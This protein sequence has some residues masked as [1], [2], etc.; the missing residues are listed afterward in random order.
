MTSNGRGGK[1]A[2]EYS[3]KR[4]IYN[5]NKIHKL[6]SKDWRSIKYNI[7]KVSTQLL[8]YLFRWEIIS[9]SG[10]PLISLLRGHPQQAGWNAPPANRGEKKKRKK[11]GQPA[12][13]MELVFKITKRDK[14]RISKRCVL[15]NPISKGSG[16]DAVLFF[17]WPTPL[18]TSPLGARRF[19]F[20][21]L[22]APG[23]NFHGVGNEYARR[24]VASLSLWSL[25]NYYMV[26]RCKKKSRTKQQ[27]K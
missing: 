10:P 7:S 8:R 15:I 11:L 2:S 14:V 9:Q 19:S 24:A 23:E 27:H 20:N 4:V 16:N 6:L 13:I 3:N 18:A 22:S 12:G 26:E 1:L 17:K 21:G 25:E 5:T